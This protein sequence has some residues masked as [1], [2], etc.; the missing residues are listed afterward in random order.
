MIF[1]T[2]TESRKYTSGT[3]EVKEL[4]EA[5]FVAL[6]VRRDNK[7]P[8]N[9]ALENDKNYPQNWMLRYP[10]QK[11]STAEAWQEGLC[12]LEKFFLSKKSTAY[13]PKSIKL[14]D[15][16]IDDTPVLEDFFMDNDIEEIIKS[17]I[18]ADKLNEDFY[19][20]YTTFA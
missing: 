20:N 10:P 14:I 18:D 2:N 1:L 9:D 11:E 13:P 15:Q 12:V 4:L 19:N 5:N 6:K 3:L 7:I 8:R 16:T 17:V